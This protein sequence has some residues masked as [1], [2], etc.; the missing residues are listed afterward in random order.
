MHPVLGHSSWFGR[1]SFAH[2]KSDAWQHNDGQLT[3]CT[4]H[5]QQSTER[6]DGSDHWKC[7]ART[8]QLDGGALRFHSCEVRCEALYHA[9][10][11]ERLGSPERIG[12]VNRECWP[13]PI[14]AGLGR[15]C[16]FDVRLAEIAT[17]RDGI[18]S[19]GAAWNGLHAAHCR[20]PHPEHAV[21]R[22]QQADEPDRGGRHARQKYGIASVRDARFAGMH[23]T[24]IEGR[25][26]L[27]CEKWEG[28]D[29]A[30]DKQRYGPRR[31]SRAHRMRDATP[32]GRFRSHQYGLESAARWW[33]DRFFW[34]RHGRWRKGKCGFPILWERGRE[35][36]TNKR[37][38]F[39]KPRNH[40][41]VHR[42]MLAVIHLSRS[43]HGRRHATPSKVAQVHAPYRIS[44][45]AKCPINWTRRTLSQAPVRSNRIHS[46]NKAAWVPARWQMYRKLTHKHPQWTA[47]RWHPTKSM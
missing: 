30:A 35:R 31:V 19:S 34:R 37:F 12:A 5:G 4:C 42:A 26:R 7:E 23:E 36:E 40:V 39:S 21:A 18:T 13:Q 45:R 1:A 33:L 46:H 29:G 14:A 15:R 3:H 24:A 2:P 17:G 47:S 25:R 38:F 16:R 28:K 10:M 32:K 9:H 8:G 22:A 27:W 6:C 44:W 41:H 11:F 43:V 20:L